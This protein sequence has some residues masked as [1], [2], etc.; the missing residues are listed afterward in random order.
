MLLYN[1]KTVKIE[2]S[3]EFVEKRSKFIGY[4]KPVTTEA[5]AVD[6]IKKIR[7]KHPDATHNVYAYKVRENNIQRYSDDGE[8]AGTAGIPV[9]DVIQ[10][11]NLTD[12]CVVVT[13]Y[14]G[15]TLLGT[16]GLVR[17]YTKGAK[18]GIESATVVEK[19]FCFK[20]TVNI[21]YSLLEKI[22]SK[23]VDMGCI[24][25]NIKYENDVTIECF[26]PHSINGFEENITDISNGRAVIKKNDGGMFVDV[27]V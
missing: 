10:K 17:A 6:F 13:R 5:E 21:D 7:A 14:F 8:P 25:G 23:T 16:G 27:E 20:Y 11:E 15:G 18:I 26:A 22:R 19:I 24:V 1:Y 9:L 2:N 3:D 4:V 12:I